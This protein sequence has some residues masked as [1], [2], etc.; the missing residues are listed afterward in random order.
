MLPVPWIS[1]Q[2]LL[3][4]VKLSHGMGPFWSQWTMATKVA[5][6]CWGQFGIGISAKIWQGFYDPGYILASTRKDPEAMD[7]NWKS[8]SCSAHWVL[9][10]IIWWSAVEILMWNQDGWSRPPVLVLGGVGRTCYKKLDLMVDRGQFP[11]FQRPSG[12]PFLQESYN[13]IY[14]NVISV[15][16]SFDLISDGLILKY[17]SS[18]SAFT[19]PASLCYH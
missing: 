4:N 15:D 18:S 6:L 5:N 17:W 8:S 10:D 3:S 12:S 19:L 7:R 1:A 11:K 14:I 2:L 16:S 13:A 9:G